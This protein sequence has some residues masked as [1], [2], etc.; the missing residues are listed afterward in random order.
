MLTHN[1]SYRNAHRENV[2]I[3]FYSQ[4]FHWKLDVVVLNRSI[5]DMVPDVER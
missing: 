3:S 4:I 5:A 1:L 2:G